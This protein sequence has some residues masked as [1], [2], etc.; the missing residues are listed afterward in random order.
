MKLLCNVYV[1]WDMWN[2]N[3]PTNKW[4][5]LWKDFWA[6]WHRRW[7]LVP[8]AALIPFSPLANFY[9]RP[10]LLRWAGVKIGKHCVIRQKIEITQ[11]SLTIGDHEA[12]NSDCRFSCGGGI[13][14]GN[15]SQIGPRV[16]FETSSHTLEP[17][18]FAHRPLLTKPI[19][20]EEY[21]WIRANAV[22]LGG[23][24]IGKGAVVAAGAVVTQDVPPFT[25]VGGVP[26]KVLQSISSPMQQDEAKPLNGQ[27]EPS[28]LRLE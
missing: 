3:K 15:Y 22:I 2:K 26:A 16:S 8:L 6:S 17:K 5:R 13:Q 14:I 24:T 25:L 10:R 21:A 19:V 23:V 12:I 28:E 18:V 9:V 20:V 11:G 1:A 27:V 7:W 4:H